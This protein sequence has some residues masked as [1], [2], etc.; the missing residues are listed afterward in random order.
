MAF[1][2]LVNL[3]WITKFVG[4]E[5]FILFLYCPFNVHIISSNFSNFIFVHLLTLFF[6]YWFSVSNF[7]GFCIIFIISYFLLA[8]GLYC[9]SFS[10]FLRCQ[11]IYFRYSSLIFSFSAINFPQSI[12]FH[13]FFF[14]LLHCLF[15][16]NGKYLKIPLVTSVTHVLFRNVLINLHKYSGILYDSIFS[17]LLHAT[18]FFKTIFKVFAP[19]STVYN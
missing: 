19:E 15:S 9:S 16:F 3:I 10:S 13:S 17:P 1:K 4:I 6:F 12:A 5:L 7:I 14:F 18:I 2:E 8:L 11:L